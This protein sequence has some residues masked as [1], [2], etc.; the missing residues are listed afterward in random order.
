MDEDTEYLALLALLTR[1][2]AVIADIDGKPAY[3]DRAML[4]GLEAWVKSKLPPLPSTGEND[5]LAFGANT[6]PPDQG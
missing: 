1:A 3:L 2:R 6:N 4:T 5:D